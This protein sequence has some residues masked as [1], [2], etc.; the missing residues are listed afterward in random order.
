MAIG[1]FSM[2][3]E[4]LQKGLN[5]PSAGDF[6]FK[7]FRKNQESYSYKPLELFV[8]IRFFILHLYGGFFIA[9]YTSSWRL[10]GTYRICNINITKNC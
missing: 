6:F 7:F 2:K 8:F 5:P 10:Q 3:K 4:K 1:R 9:T